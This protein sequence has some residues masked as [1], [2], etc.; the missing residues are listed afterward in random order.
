[1]EDEC[2]GVAAPETDASGPETDRSG[3]AQYRRAMR[4]WVSQDK[5]SQD[6]ACSAYA[7]NEA[8]FDEMFAADVES[9]RELLEPRK[10]VLDDEC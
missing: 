5:A 1:M 4:V 8:L 2:P 9:V 3:D 10:R 6:L 7:T